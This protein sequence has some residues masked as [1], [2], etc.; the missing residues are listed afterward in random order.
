[1]YV[2]LLVFVRCKR[3]MV[4]LTFSERFDIFL[5]KKLSGVAEL[6]SIMVYGIRYDDFSAMWAIH[7]LRVRAL[8]VPKLNNVKF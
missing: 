4:T 3:K 5:K 2:G 7:Y 6:T 8:A 1:M